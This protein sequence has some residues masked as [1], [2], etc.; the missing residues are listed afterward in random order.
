M[1]ICFV[2][3]SVLKKS[4]TT[5][6]VLSNIFPKI[7]RDAM[8]HLKQGRRMIPLSVTGPMRLRRCFCL[9]TRKYNI[10]ATNKNS[11]LTSISQTCRVKGKARCQRSRRQ[12][13]IGWHMAAQMPSLGKG[14]RGELFGGLVRKKIKIFAGWM[15]AYLR[16]CTMVQ[17]CPISVIQ[18]MRI[19]PMG[20]ILCL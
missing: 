14:K 17:L 6:I 8:R 10:H 15:K 2:S 1:P 5:F 9:I 7:F 12:G 11:I 3:G 4:Y 13:W 19:C 16:K 18:C 20:Y